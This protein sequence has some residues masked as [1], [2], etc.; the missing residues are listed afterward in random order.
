MDAG[1]TTYIP[2][3][4]TYIKRLPIGW[5]SNGLCGDARGGLVRQAVLEGT[6]D[7]QARVL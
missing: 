1:N 5:L 2:T 7:G 6:L 4:Q 3:C